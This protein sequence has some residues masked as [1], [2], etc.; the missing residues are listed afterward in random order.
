M[1]HLAGVHQGILTAPTMQEM[2]L[3]EFSLNLCLFLLA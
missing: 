2:L 3:E 1:N